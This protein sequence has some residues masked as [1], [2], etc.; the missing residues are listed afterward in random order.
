M[1]GLDAAVAVELVGVLDNGGTGGGVDRIGG[2][3][4]A[5]TEVEAQVGVLGEVGADAET[6]DR[7]VVRGPAGGEGGARLAVAELDVEGEG[8]GGGGH[9][10]K[11]REV[12]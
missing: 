4:V 3:D 10:G 1:R 7:G 5:G 2:D 12:A 6:D 9:Q 11:D 8:L